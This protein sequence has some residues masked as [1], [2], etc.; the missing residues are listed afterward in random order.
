MRIGDQVGAVVGAYSG[1]IVVYHEVACENTACVGDDLGAA[2]AAT[3]ADVHDAA[4][5]T[6]EEFGQRSGGVGNA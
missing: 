3:G 2:G 5:R 1:G 6:V 4:C